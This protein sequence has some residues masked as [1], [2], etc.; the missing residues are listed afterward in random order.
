MAGKLCMAGKLLFMVGKCC[1]WQE[2]VVYGRKIVVYG[3]KV[4]FM[5]HENCLW[6]ESP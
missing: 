2:S 5:A 1:L 3:R 4:L 6:Q